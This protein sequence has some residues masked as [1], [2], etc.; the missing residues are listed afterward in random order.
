M[1]ESTFSTIA[2]NN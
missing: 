1:S 2:N